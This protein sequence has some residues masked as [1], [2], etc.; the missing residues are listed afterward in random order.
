MTGF[1]RKRDEIK[2]RTIVNTGP[3]AERPPVAGSAQIREQQSA[4]LRFRSAYIDVLENNQR[5]EVI[6][7]S[8]ARRRIEI[9]G[10][11]AVGNNTVKYLRR[12]WRIEGSV[13]GPSRKSPPAAQ[14][15]FSQLIEPATSSMLASRCALIRG[16]IHRWPEGR[17]IREC[18]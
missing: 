7:Q 17:N 1:V 15:N 14:D 16:P 8:E 18:Y 11:E 4:V 13:D 3:P 6:T 5:I 9:G 12:L 2:E 10:Y